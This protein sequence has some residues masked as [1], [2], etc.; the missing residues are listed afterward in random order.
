MKGYYEDVWAEPVDGLPWA[1]EWRRE[2]LATDVREGERVLDLGCGAGHF[3]SVVRQCGAQSI[4][5]EL[6]ERALER[7]RLRE[8]R[9]ET[10]LL[11]D[12]GSIPLAHKSVDLVWCSEVIEHVGDVGGLL[13]EVRR[14]LRPGGQLRFYEHVAADHPGMMRRIQRIV[15]ATLWPRLLAGCHTGRDT[16]TAITDA[17]FV[18]DELHRFPFPASGPPSPATPHVRG[19]ATRPADRT[20]Q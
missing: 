15:D 7:A 19:A 9:A 8:P 16:L 17:G 18:L 10:H 6:A 13:A 4:G 5:V 20:P 3:L 2:L 14:V 1:W 11:A 12:D